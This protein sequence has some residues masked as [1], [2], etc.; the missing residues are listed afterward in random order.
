MS[1]FSKAR[2]AK[3]A[4]AVPQTPENG[5]ATA[6]P[7]YQEAQA[8]AEILNA[9][10]ADPEER[11]P[12]PVDLDA[13][14]Q[15]LS[16]SAAPQKPDADKCLAHLKLL[17]AFHTMKEDVGYTD[18]LWGIWNSRADV[19]AMDLELG[20]AVDEKSKPI[21]DDP[22]RK[23]NILSKIREKRWAVFVA[24]AVDRYEA[25]WSSLDY[26]PP[27]TVSS[28]EDLENPE[29][30]DFPKAGYR[31]YW[32]SDMLPPLGKCGVDRTMRLCKTFG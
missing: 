24:R 2:E 7:S 21:R 18:G 3:R 4:S 22:E 8:S 9:R 10:P 14:M 31:D 11:P 13:A 28:I 16:L 25:W 27:V 20:D 15:N 30:S 5:N 1:P 6:P 23:R 17:F 26:D 19:P 29:Y 12:P 32:T